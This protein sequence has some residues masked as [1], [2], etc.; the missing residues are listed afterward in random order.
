MDVGGHAVHRGQKQS[1]AVRILDFV[2]RRNATRRQ[3]RSHF[4]DSP[5]SVHLD[6]Q[7][8]S[9]EVS[10]GLSILPHALRFCHY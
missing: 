4:S 6:Q 7:R 5:C 9:A 10:C 8:P 1:Q 2:S 3:R